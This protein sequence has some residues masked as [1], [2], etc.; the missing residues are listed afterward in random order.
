MYFVGRCACVCACVSSLVSLS[1]GS[2]LIPKSVFY[3]FF[4]VVSKYLLFYSN[5]SLK[6]RKNFCMIFFIA[7]TLFF[8]LRVGRNTK[9]F[10]PVGMFC[11]QR[12]RF[13]LWLMFD[14]FLICTLYFKFLFN[15]DFILL[16]VWLFGDDM[17]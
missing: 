8:S 7:F 10:R 16:S 5:F 14:G 3:S 2:V 12:Y 9:N 15:F 11:G 4:F 17:F 1:L 6:I 13:L